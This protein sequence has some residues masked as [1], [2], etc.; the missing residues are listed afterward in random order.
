MTSPLVL[1]FL[2]PSYQI[3]NEEPS[4]KSIIWTVGCCAYEMATLRPAY[5][6]QGTDMFSALNEI[7]QGNPPTPL[8]ASY[9]EDF[10]NLIDSCLRSEAETRPNIEELLRV[11]KE[12]AG[13]V[14]GS[15]VSL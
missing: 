15:I 7:M 5:A 8:P 6:I 4:D 9:T 14:Q 1:I 3:I 10:R 11:A 2:I 13:P 12:K